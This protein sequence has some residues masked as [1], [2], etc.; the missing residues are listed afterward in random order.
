MI[1]KIVNQT[2]FNKICL[3]FWNITFWKEYMKFIFYFR[4]PLWGGKLYK[5]LNLEENL[6]KYLVFADVIVVGFEDFCREFLRVSISV[7]SC[8]FLLY[9]ET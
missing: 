4:T 9:I 1:K 8:L 3:Q 5:S 2:V 7:S 6:D